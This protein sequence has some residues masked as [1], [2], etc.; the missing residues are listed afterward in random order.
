MNNYCCKKSQLHFS[1]IYK[2]Y[3][4]TLLKPQ[5]LFSLLDFAVAANGSSRLHDFK[6]PATFFICWANRIIAA[7][8]NL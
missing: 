6:K 5:N 4:Q 7:D 8:E 2:Q 1:I 3:I